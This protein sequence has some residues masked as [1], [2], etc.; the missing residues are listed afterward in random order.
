MGD[1]L[2][3]D[4]ETAQRLEALYGSADVLRRRRLVRRAL[5]PVPGDRIVDVGCGPG[6]YLDEIAV[7]VGPG[8]RVVGVE[9]SGTMRDA[10]AVRTARHGNVTLLDG[11]ATAI[12]ID[13]GWADRA[14]AV[15]VLEYVDDTSAA[16]AELARIIRPGGTVVVWD[17]DWATLS[18]HSADPGRMDRVLAAWDN[19]LAHPSL[20]RTLAPSMAR[21]GFEH[22]R[23]EAY[24]FLNRDVGPNSYSGLVLPL[25]A[26]YVRNTTLVPGDEVT[27]WHA[28][29]ESLSAGGEYY[30]S[31]IQYC[32]TATRG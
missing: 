8:G 16:V 14:L 32:F 29:Q 25:I 23:A 30:C 1:N 11:D 2:A 4:R 17:I 28:E 27:A 13:D 31:L 7:Q 3:F 21:A 6:Y 26:D 19:H 9:P 15:Q 18:W 20:P 12:P 10:A 22:V 24:A 5:G